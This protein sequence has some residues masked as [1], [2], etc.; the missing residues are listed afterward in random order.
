MPL[1]QAKL[2]SVGF[3]FLPF[4]KLIFFAHRFSDFI[5]PCSMGRRS[6]LNCNLGW[7]FDKHY[8]RKPVDYG[9]DLLMEASKVT[10][11]ASGGNGMGR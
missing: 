11:T 8:I 1:R 4:T 7:D 2:F 3:F 5:F 9:D 10:R 6:G